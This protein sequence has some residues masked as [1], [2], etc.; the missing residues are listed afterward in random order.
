[1]KT[2][3]SPSFTAKSNTF[4]FNSLVALEHNIIIIKFPLD[5][6][7]VAYHCHFCGTGLNLF[8][9]LACFDGAAKMW[10]NI[11]GKRFQKQLF[12][13]CFRRHQVT[14]QDHLQITA[15]WYG[16]LKATYEEQRLT[17][18]RK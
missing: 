9:I 12:A 8:S 6:R 18:T 5:Y 1:M 13:P 3:V 4:L 7:L 14:G 15:D 16:S 2:V 11:E 10:G 17:E